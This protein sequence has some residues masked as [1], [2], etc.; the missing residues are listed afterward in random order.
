MGRLG[1]EYRVEGF[2]DRGY[3]VDGSLLPRGSPGATLPV[4]QVLPALRGLLAS[5]RF[6]CICIHGDGPHALDVA[7]LVHQEL[8]RSAYNSTTTGGFTG[9]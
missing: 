4:E 8:R 3:A 5:G 6:D 1:V 7:R 9:R 2:A